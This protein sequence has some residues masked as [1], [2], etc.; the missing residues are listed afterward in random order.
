MSQKISASATAWNEETSRRFIDYG[1]YFVPQRER[2]IQMIG[3]LLACGERECQIVE[4]CCGEGLLAE[5][6]LERFPQARLLGLDG[7]PEMLEHAQK[8]LKRFGER[9]RWRTFDL[10]T[11]DWRKLDTP[12]DAVVSSLGIHHLDGEEK[13]VLF[14]DVYRMMGKGGVFV[15]ADV[16][17]LGEPGRTLAAKIW[18]DEV[19]ARALA[20][21]GNTE[22]FD[23]FERER[24]NMYRYP[25][26]DDID[27]PSRLGEQ[28][29]WLEEAGFTDVDVFWMLAG[30]AIFGGR[31]LVR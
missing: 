6:L 8:R 15:I 23:L 25:D 4:L 7:S 17:E 5:A 22:A 20:L 28:L 3:D 1:R 19:R 24:W 10:A 9:F 13:R 2:Q 26:P 12:V 30:H 27:K 21:D 14:R 16:V 18:D 11:V 31:K 29:T